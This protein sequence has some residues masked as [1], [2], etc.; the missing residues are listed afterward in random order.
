M[1]LYYRFTTS[2]PIKYDKKNILLKDCAI[3]NSKIKRFNKKK[4]ITAD[5]NRNLSD[6]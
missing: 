6:Q 1:R 2:I 5:I 3:F 4:S